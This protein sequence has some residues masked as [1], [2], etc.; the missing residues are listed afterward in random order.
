MRIL[1]VMDPGI[2]IPPKAYGGHERLVAMFAKEYCRLGHK[3]DL[4]VTKGSSIEGCTI[5][6]L[7]KEGFPPKRNDALM[8]VVN[9]WKFL[10][11]NRTRYDLVHN[12][13]RLAYLIPILNHPVKKIMTYGR[14]I[15]SKNI[16]LIHRL[17]NRNIVFTGCSNNLVSRVVKKGRWEVV[18]NAIEFDKYTLNEKVDEDAP[19]IFLGRLER[20]K[21]VHTAIQVAKATNN[22]LIISGNISPL[23]DERNYFETEIAPYIDGDRIKY[24]GALNDDKKNQYLSSAIALLFP[25]E[26]NEPFGMVMV[27]AMACGT[28]VIAFKQGSVDEVVDDGITGYKVSNL[29]EMGDAVQEVKKIDRI[30]CRKHAAARFDVTIIA[31]RYLSISDEFF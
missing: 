27:E 9:A 6:S 18:Y 30:L 2:L 11:K 23:A 25:I 19:L 12:F 15:S 26:W 8:A 22:R 31:R 29:K 4:L 28:P 7:G 17:P 10:W 24:I 13:G 3:V 16:D 1:L 21:G 14:E 20:V 5:Y